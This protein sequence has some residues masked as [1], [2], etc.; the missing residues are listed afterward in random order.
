MPFTNSFSSAALSIEGPP[1]THK[2][3]FSLLFAGLLS[4]YK[5]RVPP[6]ALPGTSAV[7]QSNIRTSSTASVFTSSTFYPHWIQNRTGVPLQYLFDQSAIIDEEA[8]S[9]LEVHS[10]YYLYFL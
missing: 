7:S 8:E 1:S 5:F 10:K 6:L 9:S 2:Y 3:A 4:N